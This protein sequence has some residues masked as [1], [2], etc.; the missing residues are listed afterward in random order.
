VRAPISV[1]INA[2]S[3][4]SIAARAFVATAKELGLNELFERTLLCSRAEV[5]NPGLSANRR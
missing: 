4:G 3:P 5:D 1:A 2:A